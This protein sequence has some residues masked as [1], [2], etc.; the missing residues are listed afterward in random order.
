MRRA[1]LLLATL[2]MPPV[3]PSAAQA[4]APTTIVV[5]FGAGG[6][7]DRMARLLAPVMSELLSS[8]VIV[9]NTTG[10]AGVIGAAEVARARPDGTTLLLSTTGPMAIQPHIRSDLPY[11]MADFVPLCQIGDAPVMMMA[12][13]NGPVRDAASLVAQA[14]A[15]R[16]GFT[17]GSAGQGSI[18]HIV[19][20]EMARRA[21]VEMIHVPFRGSAEAVISLLRGD[22]MVYSDLPGPL[23]ANN[24]HPVGVMAA[25]RTA[26]FPEVPTLREQGFDLVH[27]I[28]TG[29]FAPAGTPDPVLDRLQAACEYGLQR[30]P[31][32]EGFRRL[33]TPVVFRNP[34]D[35]AAFWRAELA[36]FESIVRESGIRAGD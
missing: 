27:S 33:D 13:P 29:L 26:E 19:M 1:L 10:A 36:K 34:T 23:R 28:W 35:F 31:V 17:Y 16:G 30:A 7:A 4:Q 25:T 24:L 9:K 3:A 20:V 2:A 6:S 32:I 8:Q 15:A 14:R 22:V 12:A 18:P 5:N 21:N 11:R